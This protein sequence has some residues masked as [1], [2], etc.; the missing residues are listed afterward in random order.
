MSHIGPTLLTLRFLCNQPIFQRST[1]GY[2][3]FPE[4]RPKKNFRVN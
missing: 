4:G 2:A 3:G 1:L